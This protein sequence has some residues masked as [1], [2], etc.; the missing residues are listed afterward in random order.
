MLGTILSIKE[1]NDVGLSERPSL[2]GK[3]GSRLGVNQMLDVVFS[4]CSKYDGYIIETTKHKYFIL[5]NNG[6]SCCESWGYFSSEDEH[7]QFINCELKDVRMT[8]KALNSV[9]VEKSGFY[10]DSGGIQFVDF[11]TDVGI[12]QIAVYNSHNG[13]YGHP[14][15]FI[16]DDEILL[17]DTL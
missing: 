11:I 3:N 4:G 8:D 16:K 13:Y 15:Y 5:I 1:V 9:K 2:N 14:I 17:S 10:E 7:D 12:F 6:Q